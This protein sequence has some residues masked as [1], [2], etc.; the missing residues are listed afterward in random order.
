MASYHLGW[1]QQSFISNKMSESHR[2]CRTHRVGAVTYRQSLKGCRLDTPLKTSTW[3]PTKYSRFGRCCYLYNR[4]TFR[5]HANFQGFTKKYH[6]KNLMRN[7]WMSRKGWQ[8]KL[9]DPEQK[10]TQYLL[11][12]FSIAPLKFNS[13][14]P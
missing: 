11:Y 8:S 1:H 7:G 14:S 3:T 12:F 6:P 2:S 5:F 13:K 10:L 4:V 9:Q